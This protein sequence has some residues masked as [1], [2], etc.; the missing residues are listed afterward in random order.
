MPMQIDLGPTANR[1]REEVRE[2]LQHNRPADPEAVRAQMITGGPEY[3][4]W[5]SRLHEAGFLAVAWPKEYG[6]RGLGGLEVAVMNRGVPRPGV[7]RAPPGM[8]EGL[9]RPAVL[10]AALEEHN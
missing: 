1:F 8:G 9:P 3:E 2:W 7:P 5:A 4:E 6:G 10:R